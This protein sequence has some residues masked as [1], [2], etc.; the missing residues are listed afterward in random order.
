MVFLYLSKK[1]L[2]EINRQVTKISHDPH[3]I[4]NEA[5]LEHLIDSIQFKY[6]KEPEA[7]VLKAAF[8]LDYLA[9]KGHIFVEGNKRTAETATIA[10]LNLNSLVFEER[11]QKELIAFVLR[12]A[13]NEVSLTASAKWL[14]ERIKAASA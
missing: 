1:E 14:K 2:V 10:F 5:N 12:V 13:R 8:L 3:G 4:L 9:N 11:D 7:A 6:E